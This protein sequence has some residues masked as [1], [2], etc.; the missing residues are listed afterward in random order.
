[1]MSWRRVTRFLLALALCVANVQ[2]VASQTSDSE[3]LG[4]ALDYFQGEKY[5]EALLIFHKLDQTYHLN[6]RF[7][8]YMGLCYYYEWDYEHASKC[9]DELILQLDVFA[10]HERSVYYYSDAESHFNLH[11]YGKSIPLYE[12]MLLVCYDNEKPDAFYRLGLCYMFAKDWYNA[13]DYFTSSLSYYRRYRNSTDEQ[14]RIA[15]I[16]NMIR[17]CDEQ[18]KDS[19]STIV[20]KNDTTALTK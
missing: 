11:E 2:Q 12:Q 5:H 8:A 20:Q 17:G 7:R 15:Q 6:P 1:M 14:A 19:A 10:P 18:L 16:D 3:M 4:R 13:R 9:F